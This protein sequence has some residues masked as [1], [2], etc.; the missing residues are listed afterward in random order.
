MHLISG[1]WFAIKDRLVI[2]I[3]VVVLQIICF[4]TFILVMRIHNFVSYFCFH[5]QKYPR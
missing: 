2:P 4:L 5:S 1:Q 3:F